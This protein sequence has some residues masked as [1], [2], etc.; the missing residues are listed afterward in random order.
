MTGTVTF[1]CGRPVTVGV[2]HEEVTSVDEGLSPGEL[3]VLDGTEKLREG[4]KVEVR[5]RNGPPA[6]GTSAP[7]AES[8][9]PRRGKR[10]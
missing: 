3:V 7:P 1:P 6:K 10:S 2:A 4:S 9:K 5:N 8:D